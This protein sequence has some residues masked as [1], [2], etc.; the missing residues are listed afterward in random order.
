MKSSEDLRLELTVQSILD[1]TSEQSKMI[2]GKDKMALQQEFLE[3]FS[4]EVE[5][6]ELLYMDHHQY[7]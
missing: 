4:E 7:W 2:S 1:H 6:I 5:D 3:W